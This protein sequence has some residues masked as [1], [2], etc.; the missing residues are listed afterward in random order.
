MRRIEDEDFE[1]YTRIEQTKRKY[2]AMSIVSRS[3]RKKKKIY[4]FNE[5]RI[6]FQRSS[7]RFKRTYE[8]DRA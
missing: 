4:L 3:E 7:T 6:H 5:E 1:S 2:L 8:E